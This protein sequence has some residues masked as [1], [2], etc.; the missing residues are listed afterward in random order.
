MNMVP[1][2]AM[3]YTAARLLDVPNPSTSA[4]TIPSSAKFTSGT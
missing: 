4:T 2:T 3:P 1:V